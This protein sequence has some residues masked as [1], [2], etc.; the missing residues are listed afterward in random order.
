M[1]PG[2]AWLAVAVL[3]GAAV[4]CASGRGPL[5][6]AAVWILGALILLSLEL[7][8][9]FFLPTILAAD[10]AGMYLPADDRDS[11]RLWG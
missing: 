8:E 9:T 10:R 7:D 11:A 4:Y 2:L 6:A 3:I 1:L 5:K